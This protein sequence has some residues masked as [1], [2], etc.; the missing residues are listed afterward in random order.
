MAIYHYTNLDQIQEAYF[1]TLRLTSRTILRSND[2]WSNTYSK[3]KYDLVKNNIESIRDYLILQEGS[4]S[5][6]L[7]IN[8]VTASKIKNGYK[9]F[10]KFNRNI[11]KDSSLKIEA[12]E[13]DKVIKEENISSLNENNVSEIEISSKD[14]KKIKVKVSGKEFIN[15]DVVVYEAVEKKDSSQTL[16]GMINDSFDV[17]L[18]FEDRIKIT[19]EVNNPQTGSIILCSFIAGLSVLGGFVYFNVYKKNKIFKI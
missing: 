8:E 4:V 14:L 15:N 1:N 7:A 19:D 12:L 9:L 5:D 13:E 6:N 10:I 2:L 3:G 17:D 11:Q 16:I 18:I